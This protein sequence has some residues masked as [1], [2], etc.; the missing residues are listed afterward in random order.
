VTDAVLTG[1]ELAALVVFAAVLATF[2]IG[3]RG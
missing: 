1:L 3:R 2:L